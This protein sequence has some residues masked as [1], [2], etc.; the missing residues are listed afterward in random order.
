VLCCLNLPKTEE[1]V[2]CVSPPSYRP[3]KQVNCE[4]QQIDEFR[5]RDRLKILSCGITSC[6]VHTFVACLACLLT[7]A[8]EVLVNSAWKGVAALQHRGRERMV[9]KDSLSEK[10]VLVSNLCPPSLIDFGPWS[11]LPSETANEHFVRLCPSLPCAQ[12]AFEKFNS[13]PLYATRKNRLNVRNQCPGLDQQTK[14]ATQIAHPFI[15]NE[16]P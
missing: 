7:T 16:F 12:E 1:S 10:E 5:I 6:T 14:K 3:S 8:V 9:D 15:R 4:E 2:T 11:R 13:S